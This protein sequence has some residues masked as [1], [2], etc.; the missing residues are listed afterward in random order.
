MGTVVITVEEPRRSVHVLLT[1]K[2]ISRAH[3]AESSGGEDDILLFEGDWLKPGTHRFPFIFHVPPGPYSYHGHLVEVDWVIEAR[4]E[5]EVEALL[6]EQRTFILEASGNER[7]FIRGEL[8]PQVLGDADLHAHSRR[9][10]GWVGTM[11]LLLVGVALLYPSVAATR[12]ANWV[13]LLAGLGCVIL[14]GFLG[15]RSLR[16]QD[17]R[18]QPWWRPSSTLH[19]Y[20]AEP[21]DTVSFVVELKPS[22]K[23]STRRVTAQLRGVEQTWKKKSSPPNPGAKSAIS[24]PSETPGDSIHSHSNGSNAASPDATQVE[25]HH[26]FDE[27]VEIEPVDDQMSDQRTRKHATNT[28]RVRFRVPSDAPYSFYCPSAS[29]TWA[30]EVHVDVGSWPDWRRDF[31]LIVRPNI[32]VEQNPSPAALRS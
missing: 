20:E 19:D 10:L 7:E 1:R 17:A 4:V 18:S 13:T 26:F 31:P 28:Y 9:V 2:W 6:R 8:L 29:V 21:G 22:F 12:G 3:S 23:T 11:L 16:R 32:G 30:I 14:A 24:A 15:R 5:D 25:R 27:P